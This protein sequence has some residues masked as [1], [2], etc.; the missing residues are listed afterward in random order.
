[1]E[2]GNR[3]VM[4]VC[5]AVAG[6]EGRSEE[7]RVQAR[8][9]RREER[10]KQ[11][12]EVV[13]PKKSCLTELVCAASAEAENLLEL[14]TGNRENSLLEDTFE[15]ARWCTTRSFK[16]SLSLPQVI[17][18]DREACRRA[19]ERLCFCDGLDEEE[20]NGCREPFLFMFSFQSD[21]EEFCRE[22]EE[23][24]KLRVFSGF[25]MP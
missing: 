5:N 3:Y 21:Y 4:C 14:D 9:R 12:L 10:V 6:T 17:T 18:M 1:M 8:K 2:P 22:I 11:G 15:A 23:K 19:V 13:P 20:M 7:D 25:E 16:G 24:R